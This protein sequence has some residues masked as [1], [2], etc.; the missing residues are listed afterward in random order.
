[1]K[2]YEL[3]SNG[4]NFKSIG[5]K[6][7]EDFDLLFDMRGQS[8]GKI[9]GKIKLEPIIEDEGDKSL[10]IG[11][12]PRF[13]Q[14]LVSEKAVKILT[15]FL[16]QHV[17]FLEVEMLN[18]NNNF[19]VMNVINILDCIDI[20][21]SKIKWFKDNSRIMQICEYVF[22]DSVNDIEKSLIFRIK[23]YEKSIYVNLEIK[24]IIENSNLQGFVFKD[25][26]D[27]YENPFAKLLK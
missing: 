13:E 10:P 8:V 25:T 16:K 11:D 12:Y 27:K 19:F 18:E 1:M 22:N 3:K 21:K 26:A 6:K 2:I 20:K 7:D 17:E 9:W 14:P 5:R 4:D 24:K 23:G 15:P